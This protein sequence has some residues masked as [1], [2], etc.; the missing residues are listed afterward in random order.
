M[1]EAARRS[2]LAHALLKRAAL[3]QEAEARARLGSVIL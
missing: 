3:G 2:A 1:S